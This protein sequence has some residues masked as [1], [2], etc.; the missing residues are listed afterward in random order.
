MVTVL[1]SKRPTE[2]WK[3][4]HRILNPSP[5]TLQ[6]SPNN[7]N[8]HFATTAERVIMA[9][10]PGKGDLINLIDNFQQDSEIPFTIQPVSHL[11]VLREI[12]SLRSDCSCGPDNIPCKTVKLIADEI[13]SPLTHI[14][15]SCIARDYFPKSWKMARISPI[16]KV[17]NPRENS[18]FRPISILPVMSKIYE[19]LRLRRMATYLSNNVI[20]EPNISAYHKGHSTTTAMLAMRD[21]IITAMNKGEI[22]IAVMT[23]FSKAFD[24]VA[25]ETVLQKLHQFGFSK[26]ALKW[27]ASYL[28]KRKQFVQIDDRESS[29]LEVTFGVPQG[30]ILGPVLFNLYVNDLAKNLPTPVK[31]HQYADDT[32]LYAHCKPSSIDQC[33]AEIQ[34]AIDEL[35]SWSSHNNLVLNSTKTRTMLFCTQQMSR[36]HKLESLINKLTANGKVLERRTTIKLLGTHIHQHMQWTEHV[37]KVIKSCYG[38]ILVLRK[39]K[40][41][42]PYS[43]RKQLVESLMLSK[44][45]YSDAVFTPLPVHLIKRLQRVQL[46]AARFVLGRYGNEKDLLKLKWL[47]ISKRRDHRLTCLAH[48]ALYFT[49]WPAYLQL[50]Q[51]LPA[52]TLT[53]SDALQLTVPKKAGTFQYTCAKVFNSL[54]KDTRNTVNRGCFIK[55]SKHHFIAIA[56]DRL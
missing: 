46:A 12:K 34:E 53:S 26:H 29:E 56:K 43:V 14:I 42:A 4:I 3:V 51:Y 45:D 36:V 41:I 48:R 13:G 44:L 23:D 54:P 38:T 2:V 11:D 24:T 21:N 33:Y 19:K 7:L 27:F 47:P 16:P 10:P 40:N 35:S 28:S 9:T 6:I 22:T 52:R 30:L 17:D 49:D 31:A 32:T 1:S 20:L 50:K 39:L 15:N 25:Y 18:D 8:S 37:N 55:K 5:Q